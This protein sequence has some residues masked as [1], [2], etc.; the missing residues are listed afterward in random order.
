MMMKK[1]F[2]GLTGIILVCFVS[3]ASAGGK[4]QFTEKFED[5][6]GPFLDPFLSGLCGFDVL[7]QFHQKGKFTVFADGT[8][9]VHYNFRFIYS[10][11]AN[12][13]VLIE[14]ASANQITL[15]NME[16]VDEDARTVTTIFSD[17]FKGLPFKWY[18]PGTGV[19]LRDAGQVTF[20]GS[21]VSDLDTGDFIAFTQDVTNV[22]GPHPSLFLSEAETTAIACGAL[23]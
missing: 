20:N 13:R 10:N 15:P 9:R 17:T 11:A 14:T 3:V 8:A 12:S 21:L 16:I 19:L 22:K 2:L 23:E 5:S 1:L 4:P 6:G 18:Q 7:F